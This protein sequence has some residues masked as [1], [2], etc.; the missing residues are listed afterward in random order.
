M[1]G[2]HKRGVW[3]P[4]ASTH[5]LSSWTME[6][7]RWPLIT[8]C[9]SFSCFATCV[10]PTKET[11]LRRKPE[12]EGKADGSRGTQRSQLFLVRTLSTHRGNCGLAV[13]ESRDAAYP[14]AAAPASP[15]ERSS[16]AGLYLWPSRLRTARHARGASAGVHGL[17]SSEEGTGGDPSGQKWARTTVPQLDPL[18]GNSLYF[19]LTSLADEPETSIHVLEK[20]AHEPSMNT[21]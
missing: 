16:T 7:S 9:C 6:V 2:N 8:I 12:L 14:H 15:A 3:G 10:T 4:G 18:S 20:N 17:L 19:I 1:E 13:D 11:T 5:R 21:I